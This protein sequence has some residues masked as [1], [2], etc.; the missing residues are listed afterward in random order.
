MAVLE[1]ERKTAQ[2]AA[3][4]EAAEASKRVASVVP[5]GDASGQVNVSSVNKNLLSQGPGSNRTDKSESA[6]ILYSVFLSTIPH[7]IQIVCF[8][9]I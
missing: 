5:Q 3:E 8:Q 1:A 7:K 2:E 9:N 4:K 6:G